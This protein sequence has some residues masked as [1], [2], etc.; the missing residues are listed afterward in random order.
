MKKVG[1]CVPTKG[2]IRETL[3][4]QCATIE[5]DLKVVTPLTHTMQGMQYKLICTGVP[6]STMEEI[7]LPSLTDRGFANVI[8]NDEAAQQRM[9]REVNEYPHEEEPTVSR[10]LEPEQ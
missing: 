10:R 6:Q 2:I 4:K 9:R 5:G 1:F 7:V 3:R 8:T